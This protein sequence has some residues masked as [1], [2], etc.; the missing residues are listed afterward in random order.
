MNKRSLVGIMVFWVL[1]GMLLGGALPSSA[2]SLNTVSS[3][4]RTAVS[5]VI[6]DGGVEGGA[7]HGYPLYAS[8]TFTAG[9][10]EQTVF[11]NPFDGSYWVDLDPG[12]EYTV[13]VSAVASGYEPEI[14]VIVPGSNS[15]TRD[16]ILFVNEETCVAPGY[17]GG[18]FSEDFESG[19]LPEGWVNVDDA[20]T[21]EVW[22]FL[23][24][25]PFDNKTPGEG[26]FAILDSFNYQ[27]LVDN[28]DAGLRTPAWNFSTAYNV[29][30]D[31]DMDFVS[32][33][34]TA[35][36]R[37]SGDNGSTWATIAS[38]TENV[39]NAHISLDISSQAA[40]KAQVIVEFR[41]TG[42]PD[43]PW[44]DWWQVDN[45]RIQAGDCS[46]VPGGVVAGYVSDA[47]T[48]D[49]LFGA[50][51]V[52]PDLAVRSF[53]IEDDPQNAGLYWAFQ[54][55]PADPT[56][57][58]FTASLEN[59]ASDSKTVDVKPDHVTRQDF[60]LGTGYLTFDPIEF[61]VTMSMG[62]PSLERTLAI[63]NSGALPVGFDLELVN[64]PFPNTPA[65][66]IS[67]PGENL[68]YMPDTA[69]PDSWTLVGSVSDTIED[70]NFIAG[71]FVGGDFSTLYVIDN[72]NDTL[73]ALNTATAA[74]TEI[75]TAAAYGDWTG[76]TGTL[77]GAL[78][79][80]TTDCSTF[81]N[82]YTID[83]GT[84]VT[85]DRGE[86]PGIRCGNDLAYDPDEALIYIMDSYSYHLF[87]VDPATFEI[88]DVGDLGFN[89]K[90]FQGLDYE[91]RSGLLYWAANDFASGQN[92]LRLI[93]PMTGSSAL[94][95]TF[96]D[97]ERVPVLAFATSGSREWLS[98]NPQGGILQP[99]NNT[100]VTLIIDP[101]VLDH[102]GI[103]QAE[104][105]IQHDT[106]YEYDRIPVKLSY[107]IK[108]PTITSDKTTTFIVGEP[109]T[110]TIQTTG[111]PIPVITIEGALP[112]DIEFL[113]NGD[114][115]AELFGTP[116]AGSGGV[117]PLTITASNGLDP[118]A[119]QAF[120]LTV[121]EPPIITSPDRITF[122]VGVEGSF[123][124]EAVGFP[125]PELDYKGELP[126]GLA[127]I[128]NGYGTASIFGVPGEGTGDDYLL[129][130]KA[131]NVLGE[132]TQA[133]TLTVTEG[134]LIF[135]PLIV[136]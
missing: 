91:E 116:A 129:N 5:G 16:F 19:Q 97:G 80:I 20:G 111:Y 100:N 136:R 23:S 87:R 13:T 14:S 72:F 88:E 6:Y 26:G 28:Q 52:S 128:N 78:Y 110:F 127:F 4:V 31:F 106:I 93:D 101:G 130:I 45:V 29:Y 62:D 108:A 17:S 131:S 24:D 11:S 104:M 96:P 12:R 75:G 67:Y 51:V 54:Q 107:D 47:N 25:P 55:A 43:E 77:D 49:P 7:S 105:I 133:L 21:G 118:D 84:A 123:M 15:V 95:G 81:T 57:V 38:W 74:Y 132:D 85:T 73:F 134:F 70:R 76:L 35:A 79:G 86:L 8:L 61:E 50:D 83:T 124:I 33:Y 37:V 64:K 120:T 98:L 121:N 69:M 114:G 68:V 18:A 126:S 39:R 2:I 32:W 36:V 90:Q 46:L 53:A 109:Q 92:E 56:P 119:E 30:L 66:A 1:L 63:S 34:A 22:E 60:S 89:T 58:T 99:G 65:N 82:L 103:Y 10:F 125:T 40:G 42:D 113:D 41:Y 71:D 9:D 122:I 27:N 44:G 94:I 117:Y 3:S 112:A 115:T 135:L 102:P 48:G 59:Y